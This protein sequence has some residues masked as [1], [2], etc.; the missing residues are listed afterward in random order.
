MAIDYTKLYS[1]TTPSTPHPKKPTQGK[2]HKRTFNNTPTPKENIKHDVSDAEFNIKHDH[3]HVTKETLR[4][5]YEQKVS[6]AEYIK[7]KREGVSSSIPEH[8]RYNE[9][10]DNKGIRVLLSI[11]LLCSLIFFGYAFYKQNEVISGSV[12][13]VYSAGANSSQVSTARS[14]DTIYF[15]VQS[16]SDEGILQI[17]NKSNNKLAKYQSIKKGTTN[18]SSSFVTTGAGEYQADLLVGNRIISSFGFTIK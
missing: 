14:I 9:G 11:I 8:L 4:D 16:D 17:T 7:P 1:G 15:K 2:V 13:A 18:I 6:E 3:K 10:S 5:K 12:E